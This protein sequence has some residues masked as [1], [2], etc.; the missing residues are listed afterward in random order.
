M[1]TWVAH[2]FTFDR[3]VFRQQLGY[4]LDVF[5]PV[6]PSMYIKLGVFYK[7]PLLDQDVLRLGV[8]LKSHAAV[9]DH[10]SLVV[11]IRL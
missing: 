11:G 10:A 8:V 4:Y 6:E 2:E 7:I 1:A 9:A 3:I 5:S